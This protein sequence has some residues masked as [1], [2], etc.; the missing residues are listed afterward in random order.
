MD[1]PVAPL[2]A[3]DLSGCHHRVAAWAVGLGNQRAGSCS[4]CAP[5]GARGKGALGGDRRESAGEH[6]SGRCLQNK[7]ADPCGGR[8][9]E[10]LALLNALFLTGKGGLAHLRQRCRPISVLA[11]TSPSL[12][13][14][15]EAELTKARQSRKTCSSSPASFPS[16]C[17]PCPCLPS[18]MAVRLEGK[19]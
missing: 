11:G 19:A 9:Q 10:K 4:E 3:L 1:R 15:A 5:V 7:E 8:D 12:P 17:C 2:A 6:C 13:S 16:S 14:R 18:L